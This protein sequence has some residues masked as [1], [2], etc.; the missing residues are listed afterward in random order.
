MLARGMIHTSEVNQMLMYLGEVALHLP[1][2]FFW[3]KCSVGKKKEKKN[4]IKK[5]PG[6]SSGESQQ[7]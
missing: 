4:Y 7:M 6:F 3:G 2:A 5:I 1:T